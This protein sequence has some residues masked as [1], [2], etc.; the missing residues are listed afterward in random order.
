VFVCVCVCVCVCACVCVC[1][2]VRVHVRVRVRACGEGNGSGVSSL[3]GSNTRA[4][5]ELRA[6]VSK[7]VAD[8]GKKKTRGHAWWRTLLYAW[9]GSGCRM[10]TE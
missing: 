3:A 8:H 1:V 2:H 5:V 4:L 6:N 7:C 10:Q 9:R